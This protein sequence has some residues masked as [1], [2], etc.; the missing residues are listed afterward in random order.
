MTAAPS[1]FFFSKPV[2]SLGPLRKEMVSGSPAGSLQAKT[3]KKFPLSPVLSLE[4]NPPCPLPTSKGAFGGG[5]VRQSRAGSGDH[6]AASTSL[7]APAWSLLEALNNSFSSF[8]VVKNTFGLS[9]SFSPSPGNFKCIKRKEISAI[10]RNETEITWHHQTP[11]SL[12][13]ESG[14]PGVTDSKSHGAPVN[15]MAP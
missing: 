11:V 5:Q 14:T 12:S 6:T 1:K 9:S 7:E 4:G 2:P 15:Q 13:P 10:V 8:L 3:T